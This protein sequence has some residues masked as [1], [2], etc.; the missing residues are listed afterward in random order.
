MAMDLSNAAA[1]QD[2]PHH[3]KAKPDKT[4][5]GRKA[6]DLFNAG[7]DLGDA[8][9]DTDSRRQQG[10]S[11]DKLKRGVV[12]FHLLPGAEKCSGTRIVKHGP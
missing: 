2:D 10:D 8:K 12:V 7:H 11:P 3:V 9:K 1:D 5:D 6:F 4:G